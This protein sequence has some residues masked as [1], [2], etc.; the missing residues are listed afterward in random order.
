MDC[1]FFF[2]NIVNKIEE[3]ENFG[4]KKKEE[5]E[6]GGRAGMTMKVLWYARPGLL[7]KKNKIKGHSFG[8]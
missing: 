2:H 8:S 3:E 5:D 6:E 4:E 7:N 1:F